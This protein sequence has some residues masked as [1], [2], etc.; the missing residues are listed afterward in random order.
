LKSGSYF[1]PVP[2]SEQGKRT[3]PLDGETLEHLA[4][5]KQQQAAERTGLGSTWGS[6][7]PKYQDLV[8][9]TTLGTPIAPRGWDR[10]WQRLIKNTQVPKIKFHALRIRDEITSVFDLEKYPIFNL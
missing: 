7:D 1:I 4:Q 8:F 10:I 6:T 2:K 5:W 9:T 3:V